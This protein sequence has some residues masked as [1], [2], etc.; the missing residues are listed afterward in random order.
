MKDAGP[1][2]DGW[3]SI[4]TIPVAPK[5]PSKPINLSPKGVRLRRVHQ[6]SIPMAP[7]MGPKPADIQSIAGPLSTIAGRNLRPIIRPTSKIAGQVRMGFNVGGVGLSFSATGS[8]TSIFMWFKGPRKM[9]RAGQRI[10]IVT[11]CLLPRA[12]GNGIDGAM[13]VTKTAD[14]LSEG[15]N[16]F[17]RKPD[18]E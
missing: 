9:S 7:S 8:V 18:A 13:Q 3:E 17:S 6:A 10:S 1:C 5:R 4:S 14:L 12:S 15:Q 16:L 2:M 11:R